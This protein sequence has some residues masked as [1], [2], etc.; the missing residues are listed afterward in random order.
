MRIKL[1]PPPLEP[2][3]GTPAEAAERFRA[4]DP[5]TQRQAVAAREALGL[6]PPGTLAV[7]TDRAGPPRPMLKPGD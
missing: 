5:M 6:E 7:L 2:P 3:P 4:L 1:G